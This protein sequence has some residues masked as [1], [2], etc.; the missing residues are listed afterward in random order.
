VCWTK[1]EK[2]RNDRYCTEPSSYKI[3]PID[4]M[5]VFVEM[6]KGGSEAIC[7]EKER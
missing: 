3:P 6:D 7:G 1:D 4:T 5:D 2:Q